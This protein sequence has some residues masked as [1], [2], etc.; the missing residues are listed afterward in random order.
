MEAHSGPKMEAHSG[1]KMESHNAPNMEAH[2]GPKMEAHSGRIAVPKW[3]R[4]V[5]PKWKRTVVPKTEAHRLCWGSVGPMLGQERRVPLG[6]GTRPKRTP[7]EHAVFGIMLVMLGLGWGYAGPCIE[8][9]SGYPCSF[10]GSCWGHVGAKLRLCWGCIQM[11][12]PFWGICWGHGWCHVGP[13]VG[14]VLRY[15]M[16]QGDATWCNFGQLKPQLRI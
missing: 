14:P 11:N 15:W 4:I 1:P 3:K 12:M 16:M 9:S 10:L 13:Y 5:V 8:C 2:S 7:D 6:L